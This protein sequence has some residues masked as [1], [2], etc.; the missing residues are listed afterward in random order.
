LQSVAVVVAI[1]SVVCVDF[2][3][4]RPEIDRNYG[5]LSAGFRWVFWFAPL[6]L[7]T[8]LPAVDAAAD[9]RL[10]R[11]ACLL[12]L[13]LSIVSVTYPTWSPWTQPW[14]TDWF[15]HLGWTNLSGA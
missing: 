11:G 7:T 14:L 5:G 13:A 10:R 15:Y 1:T 6:W 4:A 9:S 8:M 3:L 2:Y 12:L